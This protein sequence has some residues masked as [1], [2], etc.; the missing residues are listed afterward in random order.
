M[1]LAASL[2]LLL[3][4]LLPAQTPTGAA[5]ILFIGPPGSGKSTQAAAAAKTYNLPVVA[6]H[7]LI[8]V[9]PDG[10]RANRAKAMAGMTEE[11][12]PFLNQLFAKK[13]A[14]ID[15]TKGLILD[16]YPATKDHADFIAKLSKEGK[17][18]YTFVIQL[19]IPDDVVMK[20]MK[21]SHEAKDGTLEQRLKD[22]H[23]EMDM[24]KAY[25]PAADIV[26]ID[27]T[28][29]V[30]KVTAKVNAA[31]KLRLKR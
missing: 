1:K 27:A 8:A 2:L 16:G 29:K 7:D 31:L 15:V 28:P 21:G 12:D 4:T 6:R 10:F 13:L 19:A 3:C 23:R 26:T 30:Q 14:S 9:D 18:P 5:V 25:Y 24:A 17:L 22:Y 20:R 11:S